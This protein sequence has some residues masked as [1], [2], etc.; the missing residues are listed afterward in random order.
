MIGVQ[1]LRKMFIF[2]LKRSFRSWGIQISII[3]PDSKGQMDVEQFVMSQIGLH[4]FG[5]IKFRITQ[6]PLYITSSNLAR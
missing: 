3:F 1:K 5:D 2:Q 4:K 6:K